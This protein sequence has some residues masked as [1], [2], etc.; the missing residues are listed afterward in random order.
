M[1]S[2][3]L[4]L[5]RSYLRNTCP[6]LGNFSYGALVPLH[7]CKI[8]AFRRH[9]LYLTLLDKGWDVSLRRIRRS[10]ERGNRCNAYFGNR[11]AYKLPVG[12]TNSSS[13]VAWIYSLLS[14]TSCKLGNRCGSFSL[15]VHGHRLTNILTL[16]RS[17]LV[18]EQGHFHMR[19]E[20][21]VV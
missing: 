6:S 3:P 9:G 13:V 19:W 4:A 12:G 1:G 10:C 8:V 2:R 15:P 20:T 21:P 18:W 5:R 16:L 14:Y 17:W 11:G 7:A